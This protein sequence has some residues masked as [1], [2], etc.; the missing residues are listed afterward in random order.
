[1]EKLP[2]NILLMTHWNG[3]RSALVIVSSVREVILNQWT[4]LSSDLTLT[5]RKWIFR[6]RTIQR[7]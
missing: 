3:C 4:P 7:W 1:M 5:S 6:T 2:F